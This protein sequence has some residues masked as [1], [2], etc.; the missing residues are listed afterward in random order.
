MEQIKKSEEGTNK[1]TNSSLRRIIA[2]SALTLLAAIAVLYEKGAKVS[3]L[4]AVVIAC[5]YLNAL[6]LANPFGAFRLRTAKEVAILAA[7][8]FA[9]GFLLFWSE[10][11]S[12]IIICVWGPALATLMVS[13]WN[14]RK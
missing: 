10:F 7:S 6:L 8:L 13:R 5:A 14:H 4:L 1:V 9:N 2:A 3:T 11:N 12:V